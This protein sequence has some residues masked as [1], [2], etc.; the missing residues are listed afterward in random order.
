MRIEVLVPGIRND[1][2]K[3]PARTML[4]S[5]MLALPFATGLPIWRGLVDTPSEPVAATALGKPVV[6][7]W[8]QPV[9]SISAVATRSDRQPSLPMHQPVSFASVLGGS[10]MQ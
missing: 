7:G 5:L 8:A 9:S 1:R 6:A 2:G 4:G 10:V 3:L